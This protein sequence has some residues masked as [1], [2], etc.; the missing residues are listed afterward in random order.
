MR[1]VLRRLALI[2][3]PAL[4]LM[5]PAS[6]SAF[7]LTNC[8][9]SL[10]SLDANGAT[11]DSATAGAGDA[12]QADPFL[13]DWDGSVQWAGTMGSQVIKDHTWSVSVFNIPTPLRGGDPNAGGKTDGDGNVTVGGNLPFRFTGL[14]YVSG[15]ISGTGGSCAGSGWMRLTGDA[16]GTI[17]FWIGLVFIVLGLLFYWMG[18]RGAW[19][20]A[21]FGGLL[22]GL[23]GALML[24]IYAMMFVG[25]WTPLAAVVAGILIGI[26]LVVFRRGPA[27]A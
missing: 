22:F 19:A 8:T 10:T 13:V 20:A 26:M 11:I 2:A 25:S 7:P 27:V 4:L 6:A 1:P 16:F 3:L 5:L 12:T 24:I 15:G 17:P 14:F 9:L 18:W 23:G 21:I